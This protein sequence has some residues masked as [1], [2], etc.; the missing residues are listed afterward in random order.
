MEREE[1]EIQ[2][3]VTTGLEQEVERERE[4]RE[5]ENAILADITGVPWAASGLAFHTYYGHR[6]VHM[7]DSC[8]EA[9]GSPNGEK[10]FPSDDVAHQDDDYGSCTR[11]KKMAAM[12]TKVD[13]AV[14]SKL[15][16]FFEFRD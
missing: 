2:L 14:Q 1:E 7:V 6:A 4:K 13:K 3:S 8:A 12:A 10:S 16:D 5:T 15:E 11:T 9:R